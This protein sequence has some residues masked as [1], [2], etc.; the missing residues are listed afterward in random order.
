MMLAKYVLL[1]LSVGLVCSGCHSGSS[2]SHA[3]TR[4]VAFKHARSPEVFHS[5]DDFQFE[6]TQR[7]P[8]LVSIEED[9]YDDA[10]QELCDMLSDSPD[11]GASFRNVVRTLRTDGL[12]VGSSDD[13]IYPDHPPY[14]QPV[15]QKD[16]RVL[17]ALSVRWECAQ[18]YQA[19]P[20]FENR[21][22]RVDPKNETSR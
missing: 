13:Y 19:L 8:G 10:A 14:I 22:L 9:L 3:S 18:K 20:S 12:T 17:V 15:G 5:A 2:P 1:A 4:A 11:G 6:V 16:A 7:V 21:Y